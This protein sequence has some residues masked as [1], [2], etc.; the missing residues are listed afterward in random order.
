HVGSIYFTLWGVSQGNF[1]LVQ[2]DAYGA[3]LNSE[4]TITFTATSASNFLSAFSTLSSLVATGLSST[5]L[6]SALD[7]TGGVGK[8]V[9]QATFNGQIANI[10][11]YSSAN[12]SFNGT[13]SQWD[14]INNFNEGVDK[15]DFRQLANDT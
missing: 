13:G 3:A 1:D 6:L 15:L 7:I 14:V 4:P 12:D 5:S 11:T 8:N 2:S 9:F 10:F